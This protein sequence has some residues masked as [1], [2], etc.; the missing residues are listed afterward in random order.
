MWGTSGEALAKHAKSKILAQIEYSS[1]S[2]VLA[3][4]IIALRE[5]AVDNL[6]SASQ[7]IDTYPKSLASQV[8][9]ATV[10]CVQGLFQSFPVSSIAYGRC[11]T[12][13]MVSPILDEIHALASPLS[14]HEKEEKATK[15]HVAMSEFYNNLPS[16]LRL[17][18][19]ATTQLSPPVYQFKYTILGDHDE[20]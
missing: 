5:L 3:A 9:Y 7:Y 11:F 19:T 20:S 1:L 8:L 4:A 17:P 2:L 13:C 14:I 15:T 18:A 6:S 12:L 10:T 16:H